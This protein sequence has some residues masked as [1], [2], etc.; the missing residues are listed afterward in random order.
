[1]PSCAREADL[2]AELKEKVMDQKVV[3]GVKKVK[4]M[5]KQNLLEKIVVPTGFGNLPD[6][7]INRG[8]RLR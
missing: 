1:M 8:L 3:L 4:M 2:V 7:F 5:L 6:G